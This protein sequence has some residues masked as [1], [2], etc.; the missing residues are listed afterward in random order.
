MAAIERLKNMKK[1]TIFLL[2]ALFL[3]INVPSFAHDSSRF[4]FH[5][6][7]GDL[8]YC[9]FE[10]YGEAEYG[11]PCGPYSRIYIIDVDKNI[12]AMKPIILNSNDYEADILDVRLN[13]FKKAYPFFKKYHINQNSKGTLLFYNPRNDGP[14]RPIIK[15]NDYTCSFAIEAETYT[16]KLI[17]RDPIPNN[18]AYEHE[19][20]KLLE[21]QLINNQTKKVS[22]LQKDTFLPEILKQTVKYRLLSAYYLYG[23]IAVFL[24]YE[25]LGY[26]GN[27]R[28]QMIVTGVIKTDHLI[29]Q[30][31]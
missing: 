12:Y 24:E 18:S 30:Y 20:E 11:E 28:R 3:F 4:E 26:E 14:I 23:K 16:L 22:I 31:D 29:M 19:K 5:G 13:N 15:A 17:E 27:N 25:Q 10:V 8:E 9:A 6:F 1:I 7:S 21:L 2:L